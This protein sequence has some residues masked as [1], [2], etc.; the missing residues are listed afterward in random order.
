MAYQDESF[1]IVAYIL[2][3]LLLIIADPLLFLALDFVYV[4]L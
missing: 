2:L 1:L 3:L 4:D